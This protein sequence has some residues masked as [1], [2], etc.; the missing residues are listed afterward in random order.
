MGNC[1]KIEIYKQFKEK[2]FN[3]AQ[4][5]TRRMHDIY[6]LRTTLMNRVMALLQPSSLTISFGGSMIKNNPQTRAAVIFHF[7]HLPEDWL[8]LSIHQKIHRIPLLAFLPFIPH[9]D[10]RSCSVILHTVLK[11]RPL[12]YCLIP[13]CLPLRKW[14]F[15]WFVVMIY[16]LGYARVVSMAVRCTCSWPW[17]GFLC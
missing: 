10:V 17:Y 12:Q 4:I 11:L 7:Q 13:S 14:S 3:Y 1:L 8:L 5:A 16:L 15:S 9:N 2:R 6:S